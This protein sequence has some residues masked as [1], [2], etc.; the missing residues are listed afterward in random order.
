MNRIDLA[1]RK[2]IVTGGSG[3]LGA[4]IAARLRA[5]G[6]AVANLDAVAPP[7]DAGVDVGADAEA[8]LFCACDVTDAAAVEAA[9]HRSLATFGRLDI[10]VN[11]AGIAGEEAPIAATSVE[12]WRRV[13]DVNLTG[14]FIC[15]RAVLPAMTTAGYGR[16]VNIA[17]LKGREAPARSGAYAASKAGLM[18]LTRTLAKE[19][20]ASGVLVNCVAPTALEGGM[21]EEDLAEERAATVARIPM[22]RYGRPAELAAMVAWLASE[23]CSFSTGALFD[24]S[25]GRGAW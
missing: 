1:G 9:V 13:L 3:A 17:S 12:A 20:A 10:L 24:L 2:A 19:V 11:N 21:S 6:A 5:S 22:G 8:D 16:I 15:C 18:A 7:Q 14:A 4:A 23:E 25:G